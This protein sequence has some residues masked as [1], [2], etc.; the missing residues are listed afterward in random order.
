MTASNLMEIIAKISHDAR[1]SMANYLNKDGNLIALPLTTKDF[2][3]NFNFWYA[4]NAQSEKAKE[5]CEA[6]VI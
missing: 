5:I 4:T 3:S 6:D 1:V 2:D